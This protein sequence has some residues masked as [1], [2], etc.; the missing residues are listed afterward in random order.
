MLVLHSFF[1]AGDAGYAEYLLLSQLFSGVDVGVLGLLEV[2]LQHLQL[3]AVEG[4]PGSS[5]LMHVEDV[6][7]MGGWGRYANS[8]QG[9][10]SPDFRIHFRV[11]TT[12]AVPS[13][14][15]L[16]IWLLNFLTFEFVRY[17]KIHFETASVK[18][19]Y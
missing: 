19:A 1:G 18:K 7:R 4:C 16:T 14:G 5:H 11:Y 3:V 8:F 13:V 12:K 10:V 2:L 17:L 9:T 15:A 6:Q